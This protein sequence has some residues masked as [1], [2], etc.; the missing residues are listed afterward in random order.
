MVGI[1]LPGVGVSICESGAHAT[2]LK[3]GS[4]RG[5]TGVGLTS[6]VSVAVSLF[7]GVTVGLIGAQMSCKGVVGQK[8]LMLGIGPIDSLLS[9]A[10][11]NVEFMA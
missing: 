3:L 6:I 11:L 9:I 10:Q 7:G 1:G 2:S 8:L 4:I 5:G